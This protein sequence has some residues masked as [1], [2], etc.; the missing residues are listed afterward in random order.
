MDVG[1]LLAPRADTASGMPE[2][3]VDVHGVGTVRVRGLSRAEVIAMRELDLPTLQHERRT[4]AAAMVDPEMTEQQVEQWQAVAVA[5]ELRPVVAKVL[6]LSGLGEGAAKAAYRSF[7][8]ESGPGVGAPDR[9][10]AGDDG[11][12]AA[13]G[14]ATS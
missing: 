13:A 6:D 11:G 9:G 12:A 8:D 7:R 10:E 1:R 14:D 4:L 5:G 2:D 3:D